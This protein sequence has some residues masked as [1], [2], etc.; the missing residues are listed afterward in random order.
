MF[1]S[2][3]EDLVPYMNQN[4]KVSLVEIF[5]NDEIN[6]KENNIIILLYQMHLVFQKSNNDRKNS[7]LEKINNLIN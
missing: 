6:E 7:I 5:N 4:L 2:K 1:I 3:L